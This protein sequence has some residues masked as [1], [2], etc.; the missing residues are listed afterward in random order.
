MDPT[1]RAAGLE[2][3]SSSGGGGSGN[4]IMSIP[5]PG[6][7]PSSGAA[8]PSG[9]LRSS[10]CCSPAFVLAVPIFAVL[11]EAI[12]YKTGDKRYDRLAYEFTKL[13]SVSFSLTATFGAFLTF[14]L[15]ALYPKFTNYLMSVFS[16]TFRYGAFFLEAFFLYAYYYGWGK[17]HPLV[18]LFLGIMLNVVGTGIMLI[19]NS[20]LTFMMSPAGISDT[21]AVISVS[22]AITNYTWMPINVHRVIANVAFGGSVAAAYAAFKFLNAET[23]EERAHYDW[24]GYIGNF[25]AIISFLPLPF[26][27]YWLAKEIYAY[28]Q[29]LG[30][31]MM[32]GAFS[33]LFII[34]AVLIGNLFLGAN[35][36]L[37]LGMGRVEGAQ[38]FQRFVKYLLAAIVLC[39]MIWAT[40]RSIIATVSEIRAMGGGTH[41]ILGFLGVMSAKNTAVNI[42]ILTTFMSF[43]LYRRTGKIATVSWAKTGQ[44]VQLLIFA[45]AA[46][47]VI[48]LGIY[49]YFVEASVRIGLSVPQVS[50]VLFAMVAITAI[51]VFLFRKPKNTGET[52]WGRMPAISQYVLIFIAVTFTWL[53]GLM[54]YVRSGLRQHWHVY[55]VIRD[56]SP[57][58]FTPTLGFAT[59]VV[60][61]TVLIFF[62]LIGFVFWLASLH[63]R[64][65][66]DAGTK[67]TA[68]DPARSRRSSPW[69]LRA[70]IGGLV[71][72][73]LPARIG[74][75][76]LASHRVLYLCR[77]VGA[78]EG[79]AS[80]SGNHPESRPDHRRHGHRRPPDHG[81]E[82]SLHDLPHDRQVR[83]AAVSRPRR[84]RFPRGDARAGPE[85]C[86]VLRAVAVRA[87]HLHRPRLQ[88]G[89][90]GHQ[91]AADRPHRSGDP[92]R[93]RLPPDARRDATVTL[94]TSHTTTRHRARRLA[95]RRTRK[96]SLARSCLSPRR[97]R[98]RRQ[99]R[100]KRQPQRRL[101]RRARSDHEHPRRPRASLS[102]SGSLGSVERICS[103]GR[104][105]GGS[106]AYVLFRFGFAAPIPTSV[107]S[108]YMGIVSL[109]L[110]AFVSSSEERREEVSRPLLR[111]MTEK[112]FRRCSWQRSSPYRRS[113]PR[114]STSR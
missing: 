61:V 20:W 70:N 68:M 85:R 26:A 16:P 80:S 64:P 24:M 82:G 105:R 60:S 2:A 96:P 10:T 87:R 9:R 81:G 18:H 28:S 98:K 108:I 6:A 11:I 21:G 97:R 33:W 50:S 31:T 88:P 103:C 37:W 55:G 95:R 25:V 23:D 41:P 47:F 104:S 7:S 54:G 101:P 13:P 19:A 114:T 34:Q 92:L 53:M 49:G 36:Y 94:Q 35:Y 86:R 91:Q 48:F 76:V 99:V 75:L 93:D 100:R 15:I 58:A 27:G 40:P 109:A 106:G 65:D 46:I 51:D 45:A 84:R 78:A 44:A 39:F 112:R 5:N 57:D 89:N 67:A 74:V 102:C 12:G 107:I 63:D 8:W 110:L 113:R 79:S 66:F 14:M 42:L 17:F 1:P 62:V 111:L 38:P 4:T 59:Q 73:P 72:V 22:D 3:E 52:R 69:K 77:P 71:M 83:G 43:L 56:T 32:G 29:T 30:L 90:A